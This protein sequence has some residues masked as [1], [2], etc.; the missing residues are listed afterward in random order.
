MKFSTYLEQYLEEDAILDNS[1]LCLFTDPKA[2]VIGYY[3]N[4]EEVKTSLENYDMG[5]FEENVVAAS[6]YRI[7]SKFDC[8]EIQTIH[9][10]KGYGPLLYLTLMEGSRGKGL[11]PTTIKGEVTE[12][13]QAVWNKFLNPPEGKK[14][15]GKSLGKIH[16]NHD[17]EALNHKYINV[18]DIDIKTPM[19]NHKKVIGDDKY[20]E[21]TTVIL[22]GLDS[23]IKT[24]LHSIPQYA[25]R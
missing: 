21:K 1:K 14:Q 18:V 15:L 13:A 3:L 9:A 7:N 10:L 2:K 6:E 4:T 8:L 19:A 25:N 24:K 23:F 22:E 5:M 11:C 12:E 17:N 20:G 16:D